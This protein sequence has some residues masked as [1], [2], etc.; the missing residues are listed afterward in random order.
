MI[1]TL[2]LLLMAL[3]IVFQVT[4]L[5]SLFSIYITVFTIIMISIRG[6]GVSYIWV[7]HNIGNT[8]LYSAMSKE[9]LMSLI[10]FTIHYVGRSNSYYINAFILF[11]VT[12]IF[13]VNDYLLLA[14]LMLVHSFIKYILYQYMST[15]YYEAFDVFTKRYEKSDMPISESGNN[16]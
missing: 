13:I 11:I 7:L 3:D 10:K 14:M 8:D 6:V 4:P 16:K 1:Y 12:I 9:N 5:H 2:L 15:L